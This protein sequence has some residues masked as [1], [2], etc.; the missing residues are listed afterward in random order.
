MLIKA[1]GGASQRPY[2]L[3][4]QVVVRCAIMKANSLRHNRNLLV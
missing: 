3:T 4:L 1:I 2:K